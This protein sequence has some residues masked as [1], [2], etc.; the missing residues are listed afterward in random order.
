MNLGTMMILIVE[1]VEAFLCGIHCEEERGCLPAFFEGVHL[2][3]FYRSTDAVMIVS[4][5]VWQKSKVLL[6]RNL[7]DLRRENVQTSLSSIPAQE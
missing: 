6:I 4:L 1:R 2:H 5:T 3:I 7:T